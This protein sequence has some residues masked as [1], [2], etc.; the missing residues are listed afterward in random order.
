MEEI[1]ACSNCHQPI[2]LADYFCPNC[3]KKIRSRSLSTSWGSLT[4]LFLKTVLL[5]PLGL[6]W[7]YRYLRQPDTRSKIAGLVTIA[8]TVAETVWLTVA[9][10]DAVN[11]AQQQIN[12]QINL[13]GL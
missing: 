2:E 6:W 13:Y 5:P 1:T 8:I 3:G 12:Q 11:Q 7:G 9:T 4:I 10:I